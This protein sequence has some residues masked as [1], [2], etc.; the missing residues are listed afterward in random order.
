MI[1]SGGKG[2]ICLG[3]DH[4]KLIVLVG[5]GVMYGMANKVIKLTNIYSK[6]IRPNNHELFH[7]D[8]SKYVVQPSVQ[9]SFL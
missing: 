9:Q 2:C 7:G 4:I 8:T 5:E 3:R 1:V 6:N